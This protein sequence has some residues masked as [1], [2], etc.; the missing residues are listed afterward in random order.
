MADSYSIV[1]T[2]GG[3][4]G[5]RCANNINPQRAALGEYLVSF[6]ENINTWF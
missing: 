6:P 1:V 5:R 4:V 2:I 3:A